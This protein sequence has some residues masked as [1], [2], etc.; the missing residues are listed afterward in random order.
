MS[1]MEGVTT[2]MK[3]NALQ[4]KAAGFYVGLVAAALC[5]VSAVVYGITFS[6]IEYKEPIFDMTVCILL[7]V[8]AVVAAVVLF[9]DQLAPYAPVLLCA[10]SGIALLMYVHVII[11]PVSDTIYG[12]EPFTHMN[13]LIL[14]AVLIVLSFVI[15]EVSLYMKK[16]KTSV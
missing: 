16:V 14:C 15:S 7:G 1:F 11:W 9:V 2:S 8:A 13:E 4:N 3:Q 12:I 10:G 5:V 6:G